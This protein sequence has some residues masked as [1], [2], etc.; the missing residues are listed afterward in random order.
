[1]DSRCS[2]RL[3]AETPAAPLADAPQARAVRGAEHMIA[4]QAI[5]TNHCV[6]RRDTKRE[7]NI[8]SGCPR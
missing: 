5:A 6:R 1:V 7:G 4:G 8:V 3:H 2:E